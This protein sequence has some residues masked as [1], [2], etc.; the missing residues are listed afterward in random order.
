MN[1]P[2]VLIRDEPNLETNDFEGHSATPLF[3]NVMTNQTTVGLLLLFLEFGLLGPGQ[4]AVEESHPRPHRCWAARYPGK[5]GDQEIIAV[6][7]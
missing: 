6:I 3:V 4:L 2:K 1:L 5:L 7:C